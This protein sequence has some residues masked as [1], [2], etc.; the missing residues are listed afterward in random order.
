MNKLLNRAGMRVL[1]FVLLLAFAMMFA[2]SFVAVVALT[3]GEAYQ[4]D[5][6]GLSGD[7]YWSWC[8]NQAENALAK[9][10]IEKT[11]DK[12]VTDS[13]FVYVITDKDGNEVHNTVN[14]RETQTEVNSQSIEFLEEH[15][16][17]DGD[18]D[19]ERG[20]IVYRG[21]EGYGYTWAGRSK[22]EQEPSLAS[23][24][25]ADETAE[26]DETAEATETADA[27]K[28]ADDDKKAS[29]DDEQ[30]APAESGS[31]DYTGERAPYSLKGYVLADIPR[32]SEIYVASRLM[33]VANNHRYDLLAMAVGTGLAIIALFVFLMAAVGRRKPDGAV[34][35]TWVERIPFDVY[36]L[37]MMALGAGCLGVMVTIVENWRM[38]AAL[39]AL[40]GIAIMAAVAVVVLWCMSFALRVKL[41]TVIRSCLC[42]RI[43][44]WCWRVVKKLLKWCKKLLCAFMADVK[45]IPFAPRVILIALVV[46][47]VEFIYIYNVRR[48]TSGQVFGWF[49]ER[50]IIILLGIYVAAAVKRLLQAGQEI[51]NGN[52]QHRVDTTRMHGALKQHGE[53]LNQI[54]DGMNKAIAE[55]VKSERFKT[56]LITNVSHDIKTPLTSIVNYVDLLEKE[57]IENENAKEYLAVLSRQSARLKKLI[58]DLIEASKASTGN[59]AVKPERCELGVMLAQ[60]AGEYAD[61]LNAAG[62]EL[63]IDKP[64]ENVF[65]M[66]D[67]QQLWRVFDNLMNNICKYSLAGTRVYLKLQRDTRMNGDALHPGAVVTFRNIS[68]LQLKVGEDELVERFVRG[69][70]S[71]N[72]E[73]SGLGL[74]IANSLTELQH[75]KMTLVV[76]GDLFKVQLSFDTVE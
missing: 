18:S 16:Y 64:E 55:R 72:T 20:V 32:D 35:P 2:L 70:S 66:A 40:M 53:N 51:A 60:T 43:I 37:G 68:K 24:N 21:E 46:M 45:T 13:A 48:N 61:K 28:T 49:A 5:S 23:D 65:I 76:D 52:M 62:L 69:D 29:A 67:R 47:V 33:S 44:A 25:A 38:D 41:K 75:G 19:M 1:A 59:L 6:G 10:A 17:I 31:A 58:E 39:A 57:Q 34:T 11:T 9:F 54:T 15:T 4:L 36:T 7:I 12:I 73:G 74:S 42:W 8:Y 30:T 63:I 50:V 26:T 14:G 3:S 22:S 27:P 71:R 56:E